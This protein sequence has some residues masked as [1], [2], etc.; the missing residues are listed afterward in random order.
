[1]KKIIVTLT[2]ILLLTSCT[3]PETIET[4]TTPQTTAAETFEISTI[5]ETTTEAVTTTAVIIPEPKIT[6]PIIDGS[7]STIPLHAYIKTKLLGGDYSGNRYNTIH[8]KTFESFDKLIAGKADV[9]LT[10]PITPEQRV[11]TE[12][13]EGFT[14][15][16][17]PIALEGFVFIVNPE[18]PVKNLTQA[19]IRDIYSGKITNWKEVGGDDAEIIAYQRNEISGSQSYM[20]EFM[21]ETPLADAPT[22]MAI[23]DMGYMIE[24]VADYTN[25]KYAI[26]YSVYSYAASRQ[27]SAGNVALLAVD[28]ILPS[29]ESF[30]DGSYPL[31]SQTM[32]YYNKETADEDTLAFRDYIIS[33]EGQLAVLEAG[34]IP[35]KDI[36]TPPIYEVYNEKGTGKEKPAGKPEKYAYLY[37]DTDNLGE[38]NFLKNKELEAEI[39]AYISEGSSC[40]WNIYNGFLSLYVSNGDYA[41]WDLFTG[42]KIEDFSDLFYKD[43]DIAPIIDEYVLYYIDG[44][45]WYDLQQKCDYFGFLGKID[46][47]NVDEFLI[48][49]DNAYFVFPKVISSGLVTC[50][51]SIVSEYRD[52]SELINYPE[53]LQ[54][55][56]IPPYER[57]DFVIDDPD[58]YR[59]YFQIKSNIMPA[60]EVAKINAALINA[61]YYFDENN[62]EL[63]DGLNQLD[64]N[65]D[66]E[67]TDD[68]IRFYSSR[69]EMLFDLDGNFITLNH[70]E[71][72]VTKKY[73][74]G[75]KNMIIN[76]PEM[77]LYNPK[78]WDDSRPTDKTIVFNDQNDPI[79][80]EARKLA[81]DLDKFA[82]SYLEANFADTI[83][84]GKAPNERNGR[85]VTTDAV[86][87]FGIADLD[88]D[89]H[90]EVFTYTE[91]DDYSY[92]DISFFDMYAE[93]PLE[94]I[95]KTEV[96]GFSN[97]GTT[98]FAKNKDGNVV[99]MTGYLHSARVGQIDFYEFTKSESGEI[100]A[101]RYFY[102]EI[103]T[104]DANE[105]RV[106]RMYYNGEMKGDVFGYD[107]VSLSDFNTV[108][109][110]NTKTVNFDFY[111][112]YENTLYRGNEED[113]RTGIEAYDEY[114]YVNTARILKPASREE[115]ID[116]YAVNL[117]DVF[118]RKYWEPVPEEYY[119]VEISPEAQEFY[120]EQ[121]AIEKAI[122]GEDFKDLYFI[123]GMYVYPGGNNYTFGVIDI[124]GDGKPETFKV[125]NNNRYTYADI[126]FYDPQ[127]ENPT[128]PL[129][130][131]P[132]IAYPE[133]G[134]TFFAK[135]ADGDVV[136]WSGY[137]H[138]YFMGSFFCF[139]L[140][141]ENGEFSATDYFSAVYGDDNHYP[142]NFGGGVTVCFGMTLRDTEY[143][144][145][146]IGGIS[147]ET[148]DTVFAD[149]FASLDL[150]V[151]YIYRDILYHGTEATEYRGKT[152]YQKYLEFTASRPPDISNE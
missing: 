52:F 11:I 130:E 62:R 60:D 55:I 123:N 132:F 134:E 131:D 103:D 126:Y 20:N 22:T 6:L 18:N 49:D 122:I 43:I 135:N 101:D 92:C 144:R 111:W 69:Y 81:G 57:D 137:L 73:P 109:F 27:V 151:Y 139:D 38:V 127:S 1:M 105:F 146:V 41:V 25:G 138:S 84:G 28:K 58:D 87:I 128:M 9:I 104:Y 61:C 51:D 36:E 94:P 70:F 72:A 74:D 67:L 124:N 148:H 76:F 30:T 100:F 5:K 45:R 108:F 59:Y 98:F 120:D 24:A 89:E 121:K 80:V 107:D 40:I 140:S 46:K 10:V 143:N 79:A 39:D 145:N 26:G 32:L 7:T 118:E 31:L 90:P 16:E 141:Y 114:L 21:G 86:H 152:A 48:P 77:F 53:M 47:F 116:K 2:A 19:Q 68:G 4:I 125:W 50:E 147:P 33:D 14:L 66:F 112:I 37:Y 97:E 34:Y 78:V 83:H 44:A 88:G 95:I 29:R 102:A 56:N 15:G 149:E 115:Y 82:K 35:I 65:W 71:T 42:E 17:E 96:R 110:P 119:D 136:I 64:Y 23:N 150:D 12:H 99:M 63:I 54:N 13:T 106:D 113:F 75:Y 3:S 142:L 133:D 93:N 85:Y 8:S 91:Q 117:P 129:S